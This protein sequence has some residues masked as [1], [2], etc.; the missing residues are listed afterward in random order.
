MPPA[1]PPAPEGRRSH[2]AAELA[3]G[4]PSSLSVPAGSSRKSAA[5]PPPSLREEASE[6][7]ESELLLRTCKSMR[8]SAPTPPWLGA[9]L[10]ERQ[11]AGEEEGGRVLP[12]L[13]EGAVWTGASASLVYAHLFAFP[14]YTADHHYL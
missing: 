3:D 1:P 5:P 7:V 8:G 2:S 11:K 13:L 4:G 6:V 14:F 10:P 9:A 12:P